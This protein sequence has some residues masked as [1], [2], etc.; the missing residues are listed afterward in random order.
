MTAEA[1]NGLCMVFS[2]PGTPVS[3]LRAM[4]ELFYKYNRVKKDHLLCPDLRNYSLQFMSVSFYTQA[5][6]VVITALNTQTC[7]DYCLFLIDTCL[8]SGDQ[9]LGGDYN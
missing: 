2:L 4:N 7:S 5:K 6:S 3:V 8:Q 1:I 9:F